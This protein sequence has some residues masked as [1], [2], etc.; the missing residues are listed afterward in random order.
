MIGDMI[1]KVRI[2]RSMTKTELASL[3][4]VNIGHLTHI[5]KG[6]RNPSLK[7]L[8]KICKALDIPFQQ[9]MYTYG[10]FLNEDQTA[11]GYVDYITYNK[12]PLVKM[13][14]FKVC[15]SNMPS[16]NLAIEVDND[17]MDPLFKKGDVVFVE[18]NALLDEKDCRHI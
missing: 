7:T 14:G 1:A 2:E 18:L 12:V 10:K 5:E 4:D 17:A 16:G 11:Y 9:L 13:K 15:P 8:K 6:E 3:T